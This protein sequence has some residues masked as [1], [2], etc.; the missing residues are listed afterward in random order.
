MSLLPCVSAAAVAADRFCC[1]MKESLK[2]NSLVGPQLLVAS[3]RRPDGESPYLLEGPLGAPQ[4]GLPRE[5]LK[6]GRPS[7]R[8]CNWGPPS[9]YTASSLR[10][11]EAGFRV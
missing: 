2:Q 11:S 8:P 4:R 3:S 9:L 7:T 5:M 1:S 10:V 6:T